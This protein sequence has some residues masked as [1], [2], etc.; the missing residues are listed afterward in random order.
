MHARFVGLLKFSKR[1]INKALE[2]YE[3]HWK[4]TEKSYTTDLLQLLIDE[5]NTVRPCVVKNGW[6]EFDTRK[7][8]KI[9]K[10]G[11]LGCLNISI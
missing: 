7:D 9:A 8:Y 1:G 5:K 4:L 6:L 2:L 11:S 10:G 3:N